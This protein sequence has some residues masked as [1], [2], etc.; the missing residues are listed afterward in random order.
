MTVRRLVKQRD[1]FPFTNLW[2]S[3]KAGLFTLGN[4]MSFIFVTR[5][6][7]GKPNR[8]IC[9]EAKYVV[10]VSFFLSDKVF[11]WYAVEFEEKL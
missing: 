2:R 10:S 11:K 1:K 9:A 8:I 7:V 6:K 3:L 5:I 4:R